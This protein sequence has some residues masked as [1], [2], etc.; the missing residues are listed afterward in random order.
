M[1]WHVA[2]AA[3]FQVS[4]MAS[5]DSTST[6][7]RLPAQHASLRAIDQHHPDRTRIHARRSS[8]L[9]LSL[10]HDLNRHL[11]TK[12]GVSRQAETKD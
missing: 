5:E 11:E 7:P 2:L 4:T 12:R 1:G 9:S 10:P 3:H 8:Q 6:Y